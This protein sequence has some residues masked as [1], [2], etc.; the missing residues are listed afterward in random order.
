MIAE[1][2]GLL[3]LASDLVKSCKQ[4]SVRGHVVVRHVLHL[5]DVC[6]GGKHALAAEHDDC[7]DIVAALDLGTHL[8]D[9]ALHLRVECVHLGSVEANR[10]HAVADFES[11]EL[12]HEQAF[13][14]MVPSVE[15]NDRS[16]PLYR[17]SN[18]AV[19]LDPRTFEEPPRKVD[20][21]YFGGS[22]FLLAIG[23]VL[24]FAVRDNISDVD[25]VMVGYIL[26]GAGALGIVLSLVMSTARTAS[27]ESLSVGTRRRRPPDVWLW[28]HQ[29]QRCGQGQHHPT[30]D[31]RRTCRG[32]RGDRAEHDRA[33]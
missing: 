10:A 29:E 12:S 15:H 14:S 11:Y 16:R 7:R 4:V 21:M 1:T 17:R 19:L 3:M 26:M 5:L 22:I 20:S 33:E 31:H 30:D 8:D 25:L 23:A 28:S 6:A 2:V 18:V 13:R 9:L 24:S 32:A 27:R